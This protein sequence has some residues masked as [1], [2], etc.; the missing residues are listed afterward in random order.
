MKI[1]HALLFSIFCLLMLGCGDGK[2]DIQS[3]YF[4]LKNLKEQPQVYEYEYALKDTSFKM[5]WYYQTVMQG[6]SIYLVGTCYND[7][8]QQMLLVREQRF[9]NG[10]KLND[11]Y[12]F[13]TDSVGRS[14]RSRAAIEGG[15]V[16]PFKIKDDKGVFINIL[17]YSDPKDSTRQTTITRNRRFIKDTTYVYRD[18][19]HDAIEFEMKEEQAEKDIK[20]GG[21]SHIYTIKEIYVKDIGL[22]YTKR[23]I[24]E[25][26]YITMHL[27]NI[28]TMKELEEK[29]RSRIPANER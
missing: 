19:M 3:Y 1:S 17:K 2:K 12:Y 20:K 23:E 22:A 21:F 27:V 7:T 29:F 5:Y 6:D 8:Y 24:T 13:G 25:G 4:P 10:M 14:V 9:E 15:A 11:L 28:Y 16:F 18:R 26:N